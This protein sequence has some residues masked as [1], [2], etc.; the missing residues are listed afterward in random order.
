MAALTVP[1]TGLGSTISGTGLITTLVKKISDF[2]ITVD[3]LETTH[4]GTTNMKTERPS[5]LRTPGEV[6]VNFYWT[7]AAPPITTAMIP[8]SEPYAGTTVTITYSS[9]G[10]VTFTGFVKSVKFPSCEQGKILEGE[11]VISIDGYSPP[12]FT[13]A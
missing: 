5:D 8:T 12:A 4:L 13:V 1:K 10:S 11:Y 3:S 6:T 2:S 7:G 9:A